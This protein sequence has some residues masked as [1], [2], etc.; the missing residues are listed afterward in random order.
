MSKQQHH[1]T[2]L[3][4]GSV[5]R[6]ADENQGADE[7]SLCPSKDEIAQRAFQIYEASGS[8]QS[9]CTNNWL[10]AERE[11][12]GESQSENGNSKPQR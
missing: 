11:L 4:A 9:Q 12:L 8:Q 1:Q 3:I 7:T 6:T 10:R 5:G 2:T